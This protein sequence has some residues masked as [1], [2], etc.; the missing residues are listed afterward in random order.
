MSNKYQMKMLMDTFEE[1]TTKGDALLDV[2]DSFVIVRMRQIV[3][4]SL[5]EMRKIKDRE[6]ITDAMWQDYEDLSA[7][8]LAAIRMLEYMGA[9]AKGYQE[10]SEDLGY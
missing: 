6:N 4:W 5:E 7:D 8:Y 9:S 3:E 1:L 2:Y 10:D